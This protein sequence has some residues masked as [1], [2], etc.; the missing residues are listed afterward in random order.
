MNSKRIAD[1]FFRWTN[2][3]YFKLLKLTKLNSHW[4]APSH[5]KLFIPHEK[6]R[7][8]TKYGK[9]SDLSQ[10]ELKFIMNK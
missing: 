4:I 2:P 7:K 8:K 3:H 5:P 1:V 10:T 6:P 9:F